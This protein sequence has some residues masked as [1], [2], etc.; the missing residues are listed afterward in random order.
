MGVTNFENLEGSAITTA[1]TVTGSSSANTILTGSGNDV[2]DG[3]GGV[4]IIAAGAG[5]DTAVYQG[6]EASI[7]GGA[8]VNTLRMNVATTI[9][10]GNIDQ[11]TG[12][13]TG[14]TN[15]QNVDA[16]ALSA[17]VSIT[18]SSGANTIIGGSG[19][20]T[21]D[22]GG[23][24]DV[25]TAGAGD[26]T[27]SY[28]GS[29]I[30]IDAEAGNNTLL[31]RTAATVALASA[32][33]TTGDTVVVANFQN[34]DASLLS[35]GVSISGSAV[36]NLITGS[37]G[38][39]TIDGGGGTDVIAAGNGN[40][41]VT[42]R[43]TETSIDGGSGSDTLVLATSGGI[44]SINFVVAAGSDQTVGDTV[45]VA[46]FENLDASVL[47][48]ALTVVG[49]AA[50]NAITTGS[51]NDTID[52]GGGADVINGGGGN[53]TAFYYGAETSIDGG[54]GTNTL[55]LRAATTVNLADADQTSGDTAAVANFQNVDA[56]SLAI[57][58]S[59]TGS[60]GA[61]TLTGGAGNDSIDGG[62]GA[63][64]IAAGG[65]D[66]TVT[67]R[68]TE[69]SVDGGSGV[70]TLV[71]AATGGTTA[72][73]LSVA[74]GV[75]QTTGDT[76][77]VRNF[78]NVDAGALT[79]AISVT[80]S[81]S[82]NS[83]TTGSG[84]D[85][86][87]G[88]GGGDI[89][90]AGTGN[91]TV[92]YWGTETSIDGGAGTNTLLLRVG[93]TINLANADQ[94]VSD[95][96]NVTNFQNVDASGLSGGASITGSSGINIITGSGFGDMVDG[97]GGADVIST[98]G[99][100]DTVIYRGT[101]ASIDGGGDGGDT[102]V[103]AALGG[104]TAVNFA[105]AAG[106]DQTIGDALSVT[107]FERLNASIATTAL[108]VTGSSGGNDIVTGS[109][110][111][112]IDGGGGGDAIGAGAGDDTV[113]Y[114]ASETNINGGA[115]V[116]TLVLRA[117]ATVNLGNADQTTGD[118]STVTNFQNVD[119]S[120]VAAGM[121]IN[122]SSGA[123]V[124]TGG[125]GDD[126]IDG[127]AGA[128]TID[129]GG[130]NDFISYYAT[131]AAISGGS[132]TN[133]LILQTNVTV[134]LANADQT[135]GDSVNVTNFQNVTAQNATGPVSLTGSAAANTITGSGGADTIDGG[136]GADVIAAG[137]GNDTVT[138][139]GAETSID[140]GAGT[141]ALTLAAAG[142][143][144]QVDLSVIAGADQTT[145]DSTS[146]VNFESVNAGIL[147]SAITIVGSSAAN[148][149]TT[150]SGDDI[151]QGNAG[152]DTIVAGAGNDTVDYWGA[153][154]SIDG[155][156]GNNTLIVRSV[157]GL[158]SVNLAAAAGT[159]ITGGDSISVRN[160][161]NLD[162]SA[163]GNSLTVTGS[164][165][166]N[167]ITT[168]SGVDTIDGGGGADVIS[169]GAGNDAVTYRGTE[170][171]IDAGTATDTLVLATG[172]G[173]TAVNFSVA[174]GVDQT[175]GDTVAV[176]NFE[177]LNAGAMTSGVTVT[178]STGRNDV[179]TG[180]GDD[181]IDG[182][183][184]ADNII[185]GAGNDTV[186]YRGSES[187]VD[188]GAGTNTLVMQAAAA[189]NLVNADQTTGDLVTVTNFQNVNASALSTAISITGSAG[190]NIITGGS[191]ADTI[192]GN[193][194]A[195]SLSGGIGDDS[196][197]YYGA[198]TA[199]DGGTG[200]NTL[201]L[202][203]ATTVNLGG[204]DQTTGDSVNVI[205]FLNA[206]ASLVSATVSMTGTA[207]AN[208]LTG[209][210]GND[211]IDGAGGADVI[212]AGGGNDT[213]TYR[214]TETSIDGG[215]G[216][217]M[218]VLA[219]TG[220]VTAI[221]LAVAAGADQTTGDSA[222]IAN[223]E[224]VNAG[225]F[226]TALTVTA[227][228]VANTITTGSGNDIIDGGGGADVISAGI[229]NDTV[230]YYGAETTVDGGAGTNTLILN[231]SAVLNLAN[232]NQLSFGAGTIANFQN[233]DASA[234]SAA[235]SIA[236]SAGA[237]VITGGSG[238]DTI[239]GA[240]GVDVLATG[241][242]NDTVSYYGTE[243]SIDG[244]S[245]T[246]TL[247]LRAATTVNL[248]NADQ[249][250]GDTPNVSNFQNLDASA[251]S[252]ALTITGSSAANTMTGGSSDDTIDGAGGA[253]V[254]NAGAGN[255]TVTVRGSET[256]IDG[257]TSTDTL[258]LTAGS[259]VTAVNFAVSSG[260]DQT[261]GDSTAVANFESL[262]ASAVTTAISVAGLSLANTIRTGSGNDT[263]D[264]GGGADIVTA[265]AGNDSVSY[266]GSETSI[267]GGADTNTLVLR[268]AGVINLGNADQS[269]GDSTMVTNFQN[270]DASALS[271]AASITG[272]SGAN[273][274]TGGT[275]ADTIDG[276]GGADIIAA[277]GG[278][279]TVTYRGTETSIDGGTG[280]DML[281][282]AVTGG[283]TA[284]NFAVAAGSDQTIG[285]SVGIT[286]FEN[287]DASVFSS[288][289]TVTGASSANTITT[290]S[291]ND[292]IDG[293]GGTDVIAA[294]AGN[295]GVTYR[296]SEISIDGGTGTN[297]LVM[298]AAAIVNLGN[299]DQTT[300]NSTNVG[301]FQNVDASALSAAVSVTGTAAANTITGG[302]GSDTIDGG[303]GT[304]VIS[305]GVGNDTV[306]YYGTEASIDGGTGSNTL[307]L[308]TAV[309]V[310]LGNIDVTTGDSITAAN[311]QNANASALSS[312]VSITGSS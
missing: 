129:G 123:N 294:G 55:I 128:D 107:N 62:G 279:D 285:D 255:D 76:A 178:G 275:G 110:A 236:G 114:Y 222:G 309:T 212:N 61:N 80:G 140:G 19:G 240:G 183:G 57:G 218:L 26:D 86:I 244:G 257:G 213:V 210:S 136:G 3:G 232:A 164:S 250:T 98:G 228:S 243:T 237:N 139:R 220:G 200:T 188:G 53:D 206:D 38:N 177:Y 42:Y 195:D 84:N 235:V 12:D 116:N 120:A 73:D 225:I 1:L 20:D 66:D 168:G 281:V 297:T 63:D 247:I 149:I 202:H 95:I 308:R 268:A 215:A 50:A 59:L 229:G 94:T 54:T 185:A 102:L 45:S 150:G 231:T 223:F 105:V 193:G 214:A 175:T 242:G 111:D 5:D 52:G 169:A 43:G 182:N 227:S 190:A 162:S 265:G 194:G 197:A 158:S 137:A 224:S 44:T 21:I 306:S 40:N 216:T 134:N 23:G 298:N 310:N 153:E 262:D 99:G 269:S 30:S 48:T 131:A 7:D 251:V 108:T 33:Q 78:E 141:D 241:A 252:S 264:G 263:I 209:G 9:N 32:D 82:G 60:S 296:G 35:T 135:T 67:Y 75:D 18:G 280:T 89:V 83:I 127:G 142:S 191:G 245:G 112:T 287:V 41:S 77:N 115:G 22:G 282:L 124:L 72:V 258:I 163:V 69:A 207:A 15:F 130:G 152:A 133:T 295:D 249:T 261:T 117:A 90:N 64:V 147:S 300:G 146:V 58:V 166:V 167:N 267:D 143:I 125:S 31:L 8:G 24:S 121:I 145:G 305:A 122:G 173:I 171:S 299:A 301:N 97:G 119:G 290:G 68:G 71:M 91:D 254:I 109:G 302:S 47:T 196:I 46:N 28:R 274:I 266:Y 181:I 154:V 238:N 286:N 14:V 239:D 161:Q 56:S 233:V 198:E 270:V 113:H 96:A 246:N 100:N 151:I 304:D 157:S 205:N 199:V 101:E 2:I 36:T 186:T 4:D 226:T 201:V 307:L 273:T 13:V 260:L 276:A 165:A 174:A 126:G 204:A 148:V 272:S 132:G 156:T 288:A 11:T 172:G 303:G 234:V 283:T 93:G 277:G 217:D 29:E 49:S 159:D 187:T 221:N 184:G 211:T 155:G 253:D 208:T 27:V 230:S 189:V 180:S 81:T 271:S 104:I 70:D 51:G 291:G 176:S 293:G 106:V 219:A 39:D 278:N 17:A 259:S 138:Y 6:T 292:T 289:L 79:T 88:N 256:S 103:L 25:I 16:S 312:A 74:A 10:L 284:V 87:D 248:G 34:V 37:S 203:S 160:F 85:T 118:L 170:V 192:D 65:G 92:A 311:F 144:T 179:T